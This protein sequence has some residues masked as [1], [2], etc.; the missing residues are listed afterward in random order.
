[1]TPSL[2]MGSNTKAPRPA[3]GYVQATSSCFT[4][5][6]L[7]CFSE[8]YCAES[9][10]PRYSDQVAKDRSSAADTTAVHA[11]NKIQNF[12]IKACMENAPS[13]GQVY[14]TKAFRFT[15]N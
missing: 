14:L 15:R 9:A 10:P 4:L 7:I 3:S 1:M 5:D 8:E 11:N 6:L 13:R 2:T 12:G